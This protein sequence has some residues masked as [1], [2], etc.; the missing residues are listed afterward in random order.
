MLV[1]K[2]CLHIIGTLQKWNKKNVS[3]EYVKY[4]YD[5]YLLKM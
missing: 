4:I 3:N 2:T 1:I 5:K